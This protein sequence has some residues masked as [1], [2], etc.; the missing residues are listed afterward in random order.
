MEIGG[1][2]YN[3]TIYLKKTS[4][5]MLCHPWSMETED[6]RRIKFKLILGNL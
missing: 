4:G 1:T 3:Y 6:I 2:A 5:Q